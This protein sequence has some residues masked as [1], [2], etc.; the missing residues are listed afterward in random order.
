MIT[1]TL[2]AG[3]SSI[4]VR[5]HRAPAPISVYAPGPT[6]FSVGA[7]LLTVSTIAVTQ[8]F[9]VSGSGGSIRIVLADIGS[10]TVQIE[11]VSV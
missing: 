4:R 6:Q 11:G 8:D 9:I 2:P 3:T 5:G 7:E 1:V 10:P